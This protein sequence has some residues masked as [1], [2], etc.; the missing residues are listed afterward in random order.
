MALLR[1]PDRARRASPRRAPPAPLEVQAR[2]ILAA[3][4]QAVCVLQVILERLTRLAMLRSSLVH[5]L[6]VL[7]E[8]SQQSR[9]QAVA[10]TVPQ[11][12]AR[13]WLRPPAR[14]IPALQPKFRTQI[15]RQAALSLVLRVTPSPLHA[16]RATA[17]EEWRR[18]RQMGRLVLSP[19]RRISALQPKFRTQ[20][21]RQPA[22]SMELRVKPSPLHAARA[23]A[24][25]GRRRAGLM[26]R[27]ARF[28]VLMFQCLAMPELTMPEKRPRFLAWFVPRVNSWRPVDT[29]M[30]LIH[31]FPAAPENT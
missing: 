31:A 16:T 20:I 8:L 10:L 23:T 29:Q 18:A 13:V 4:L 22:L 5:A 24:E 17:E 15:N 28:L 7:L 30:C 27:L 6:L 1:T 11:G 21:F 3:S 9:E 2:A 14:R 19:A 12:L 25:E 26:G